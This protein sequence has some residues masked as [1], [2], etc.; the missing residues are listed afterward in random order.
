MTESAWLGSLRTSTCAGAPTRGGS[1]GAS[2]AS[3]GM[4]GPFPVPPPP[5]TV[6]D[7]R[8]L[9]FHPTGPSKRPASPY[10]GCSRTSGCSVDDSGHSRAVRFRCEVSPAAE[11]TVHRDPGVLGGFAWAFFA[12]RGKVSRG[13]RHPR[14]DT[15]ATATWPNLPE[16]KKPRES[17]GRSRGPL[18]ALRLPQLRTRAGPFLRETYRSEPLDPV[19]P[20]Q[21]FP[22][23]G[24]CKVTEHKL[25]VDAEWRRRISRNGENIRDLTAFGC[26]R[27]VPSS[28]ESQTC[29]S[30]GV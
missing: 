17:L 1:P 4:A 27:F 28:T 10:G 21:G 16:T 2:P 23:C 24:R 22:R 18:G 5:L 9:P 19:A 15:Q 12:T 26:V 25:P 6:T 13:P 11:K 29:H 3:R 8:R 20:L 7:M 14:R 30:L